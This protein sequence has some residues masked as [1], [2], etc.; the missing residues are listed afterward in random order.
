[1]R[2]FWHPVLREADLSER[3]IVRVELLGVGIALARLNGE[4]RALRDLCRHF[5]AQLS[6]GEII[7]LDG[8]DL[9]MCP[10]HGWS[11][12]GDGQCERIP[13]LV[14][15]RKIPPSAKVDSYRV[16]TR[17]GLI[18]VCLAEQPH[19]DIPDYPEWLDNSY[20]TV[21]MVEDEV[22]RTSSTRM[23]M[24]TL[25][26]THFPWVHEGILG[27]RDDPSPPEHKVWREGQYLVLQYEAEQP[28]NIATTDMSADGAA[29]QEKVKLVYTDYV[30]MP[31]V[32]RLVKDS[33]AGRYVVWLATCPN[34]YNRT[35]NFWAFSRN[36][37]M[38]PDR[39]HAYEEFSAHVRS[40]DR[41]ILES[42]RPWLIP[43]FWSQVELPL[44]PADKP[45]MEFQKWLEELGIVTQI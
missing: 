15:G 6:L 35:T 9:V 43:P 17:Y 24:G 8:K 38:Q 14:A 30:G 33:V 3:K 44:G 12:G 40:Q 1:M 36:Y 37:D 27:T 20:R 41:P 34:A 21:T 23:I 7:D 25:D 32:I 4:V 22:T 45:L 28:P 29:A 39:D 11:Y 13:Q 10:Y 31:N 42:Q 2:P 19:F 5:Q 18:W 26:D 16:T